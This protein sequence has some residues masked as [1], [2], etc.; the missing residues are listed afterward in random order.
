MSI[1]LIVRKWGKRINRKNT[2]QVIKN[3]LKIQEV[4]LHLGSIS[5]RKSVLISQLARRG[6]YA[7]RERD[8][9]RTSASTGQCTQDSVLRNSRRNAENQST[10]QTDS[11]LNTKALLALWTLRI[12]YIISI[13]HCLGTTKFRNYMQS[14]LHKPLT[15][16]LLEREASMILLFWRRTNDMRVN[17]THADVIREIILN[18]PLLSLLGG[19]IVTDMLD[20]T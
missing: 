17:N 20:N 10:S 18:L 13:R 12:P 6:G 2:A 5:R 3:N 9:N 19:W 11:H 7:G 14:N 4:N 8:E 16:F 15:I 1:V